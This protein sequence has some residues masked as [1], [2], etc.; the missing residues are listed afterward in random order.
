VTALLGL[1]QVVKVG[2]AEA[3][4]IEQLLSESEHAVVRLAA[5]MALA[6]LAGPAAPRLAIELLCDAII[7]PMPLEA[8]R[9]WW[10]WYLQV[11]DYLHGIGPAHTRYATSLLLNELR[12]TPSEWAGSLLID[13]LELQFEPAVRSALNPLDLTEDQRHLLTVILQ[14]DRLWDSETNPV[15][16]LG[17]YGLPISRDE[18]RQFVALSA[19]HPN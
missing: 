7:Y 6:S 8:V 2:S 5:A 10:P 15:S 13:I 19:A 17:W 4:R 18:L 16:K 11:R 14:M 1:G 12:D 3:K 9:E